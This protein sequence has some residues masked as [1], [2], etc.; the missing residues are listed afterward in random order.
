MFRSLI[1]TI[2]LFSLAVVALAPVASAT[3]HSRP[4]PAERHALG[5]KTEALGYEAITHYLVAR[6]SGSTVIR[7]S[8]TH[9][10]AQT[11]ALGFI[12]LTRYQVQRATTPSHASTRTRFAWGAALIGAAFMAGVLLITAAAIFAARKR[13]PQLRLRY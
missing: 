3:S 9:S 5:S 12:R 7:A 10:G 1:R 13:T 6:N 8:D 4:T 11:E 2:A